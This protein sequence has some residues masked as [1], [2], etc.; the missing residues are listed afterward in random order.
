MYELLRAFMSLLISSHNTRMKLVVTATL[1][2]LLAGCGG[3][4]DSTSTSSTDAPLST[5]GTTE[6]RVSALAVTDAGSAKAVESVINLGAGFT[7]ATPTVAA[8]ADYVA[9]Y[10]GKAF[11]VDNTAGNDNNPGTQ[12]LPW[13]S[14]AKASTAVLASG[15]ALL[16]KCGEVW[17][18]SLE[19]D[20]K[21]APEGNVLI[22]GYGDCS[23]KRRPVIRASD[24]VSPTNWVRTS[25]TGPVYVKDYTRPVNRLM[26]DGKPLTLARYPNFKGVGAEFAIANNASSNL[27]FLMAPSDLANLADKDIVG[28]TI[29][30]KVTQW[31]VEKAVITAFDATT[32]RVTLNRSMPYRIQTGCGYIIEGKRWMLDAPNEWFFDDV[33]KQLYL[34]T[35]TG[36]P[37]STLTGLEASW[38]ENGLVVKWFSG[39][40]IERVSVEQAAHDGMELLE[41]PDAVVSDV[42]VVQ[43]QELGISLLTSPRSVVKD[44]VV[45]GAGVTAIITRASDDSKVQRNQVSDTGMTGQSGYS[46]AAITIMGTNALAEGNIVQRSSLFGIRFAN[47]AGAI[48]RDNTVISSCMRFTD[49]AGI[50]TYTLSTDT[51]LPEVRG[52]GALVTNNVVLNSISN[53]EGCGYSCKN[54]AQGIYLDELTTGV[55]ITGNT[56][57]DVETGIGLLNCKFN[58]VSKNTVRGSRFASFRATQTRYDKNAMRG[59]LIEGNSFSSSVSMGLL[60]SGLPGEVTRVAGQSWIHL[61]N[62]QLM[63]AG[64]NPNVVV[65][66]E[67]VSVAGPGEASWSL[68]TFGGSNTILKASSWKTYA[69]TDVEVNLIRYRPY[70]ATTD[71]TSLIQNGDFATKSPTSWTPSFAPTGSGGRFTISNHAACGGKNCGRFVA[72]ASSDYLLSNTFTLNNTAGQNLYVLKFTAIGGGASS[73]TRAFVRRTVSP[74]DNFGLSLPTTAVVPGQRT[75]VETFFLAN[76]SD[77]GVLDLRGVVAGETFFADVSLKRVQSMAFT[78]LTKL[79]SHVVNTG[80][81]AATF[82]CVA[83][84][85]SSCDMIDETGAKVVWPVAVPARSSKTLYAKDPAWAL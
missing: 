28:A 47:R 26:L 17:R 61:S 2:A 16:L 20:N 46:E 39:P 5:S 1:A 25:D 10:T 36:A 51:P 11:F 77:P 76:S 69:P 4:S 37:A 41:T 27:A 74:W 38:R 22:G 53:Q 52:S 18:E 45:E 75:D 80:S 14:L 6:G 50:Y 54:M 23:G 68:S 40:R 66:N 73:T 63:F 67:Y 35:P 15:D 82:P 62:P 58:T 84:K 43:A 79:V 78:D 12:A 71:S 48:V 19:V 33:A 81:T 3:G 7:A 60:S 31:K 56:I 55:T 49:C 34:W 42:R 70:V 32:G 57:S 72:G 8:S 59:N 24:W 65:G 85:V 64:T 13:K 29:Y 21:F 9:S 44:S 30:I 83:M